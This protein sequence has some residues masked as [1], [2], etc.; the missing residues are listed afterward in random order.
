[1]RVWGAADAAENGF[2]E[3]TERLTND[4][5]YDMIGKHMNMV[6]STA[7]LLSRKAAEDTEHFLRRKTA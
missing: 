3:L 4:L 7:S 5:S 2:S 6:Y 1:M